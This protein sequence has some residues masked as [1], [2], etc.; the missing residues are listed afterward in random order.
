MEFFGADKTVKLLADG[1]YFDKMEDKDATMQW[2][3]VLKS[4]LGKL[5]G[6]S[7]LSKGQ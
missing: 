4:M 3:Q 1:N 2:P 6:K 5:D 7:C